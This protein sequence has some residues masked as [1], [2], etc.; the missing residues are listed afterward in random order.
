MNRNYRQT[1]QQLPGLDLSA[2]ESNEEPE[3]TTEA[4]DEDEDHTVPPSVEELNEEI[5]KA[6][7]E[8]AKLDLNERRRFEYEAWLNR[9]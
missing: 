3:F 4:N 2:W 7:I 5:I 8:K 1:C 6:A 9:T